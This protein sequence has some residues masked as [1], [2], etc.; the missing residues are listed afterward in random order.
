[1]QKPHPP[2]DSRERTGERCGSMQ[3]TSSTAHSVV[4]SIVL[5]E[6]DI[7]RFWS[8]VDKGDGSGCWNWIGTL[9]HK[10]YGRFAIGRK[11]PFAHRISYRLHIG[12]PGDLFVCHHCDNP[13][14]VRP[15]HFF[16]GT[17][18]D[19]LRD[20]IVKGR[21]RN[22]RGDAHYLRK[23]PE[24]RSYGEANGNSKLTADQ[25]KEI[26]ASYIPRKV[27][28]AKLAKKFNVSTGLI[29]HILMRKTWAH[30]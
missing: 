9:N 1:M 29:H 26:R 4:P 15:N 23:Y 2:L 3:S 18:L 20:S 28:C 30:V 6:K 27:S 7:T 8:K 14:C 12:E 25:V 21:R 13:R 17:N 10:G 5:T 22:V 24:K 19:N 16:L 11:E